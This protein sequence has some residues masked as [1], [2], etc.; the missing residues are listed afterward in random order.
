MEENDYRFLRISGQVFEVLGWVALVL[1]ALFTLV[2]LI[3]GGGPDSPRVGGFIGLIA[4]GLYF[5]IFRT[6]GS[7]V[8][9]LLDLESRIK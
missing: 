2:V 3:G 4:G 6:I 9:L 8:R 7:V 5:L 1:G